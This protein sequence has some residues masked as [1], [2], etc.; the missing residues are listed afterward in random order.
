MAVVADGTTSTN[1]KIGNFATD[2]K[3]GEDGAYFSEISQVAPLEYLESTEQ[4]AEFAYSGNEYG[5]YMAKEG[6]YFD[7]L[8]IDFAYEF[9]DDFYLQ[10]KKLLLLPLWFL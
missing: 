2:V 7:L 10:F 5:F 4:N 3:A 1:R 6:N 9:E 8:L